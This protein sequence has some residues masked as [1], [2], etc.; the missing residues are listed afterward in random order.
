MDDPR[1]QR[2]AQA[3]GFLLAASIIAG[4]VGGSL[5]RE[6]SIGF[7]VGAGVG[8]VLLGL[9]WLKDRRRS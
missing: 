9:V 1:T 3:G 5:V 8:L 6:P 2:P 4:V 7:F